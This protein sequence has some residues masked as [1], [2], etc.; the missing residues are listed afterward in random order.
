MRSAPGG[1][2]AASSRY[3]LFVRVV[4]DAQEKAI[5]Q[6]YR[7]DQLTVWKGPAAFNR[8]R[9]GR[10]LRSYPFLVV[11]TQLLEDSPLLLARPATRGDADNTIRNFSESLRAY[12]LRIM[13]FDYNA[14]LTAICPPPHDGSRHF[15]I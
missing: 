7:L 8:D 4:L 12:R 11:G 6:K 14:I 9:E 3:Y 2:A 5:A 13:D 1:T 10:E 15:S